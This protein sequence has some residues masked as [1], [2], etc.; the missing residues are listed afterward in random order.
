MLALAI[1]C[2]TARASIALKK[3]D[4]IIFEQFSNNPKTH[5]EFLN[6]SIQVSLQDSGFDLSE[7]D[8]FAC[9][10]GPGSFTGIRVASAIVKT[11]A[12]L[13]RKPIFV[14]DSLALLSQGAYQKD[15][16]LGQILCLINAHK[17][18]AY[19]ALYQKNNS[20]LLEPCS[21]KV[22]EIGKISGLN[23]ALGLG[24]GFAAYANSLNFPDYKLCFRDSNYSDFPEATVLAGLALSALENGKT[25]DWNL[26]KPL[27]IRDSEAEE[28]LR[29]K[30]K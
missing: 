5:S 18:M 24:D 29:L 11:F 2:S 26:Y 21:L 14:I 20:A 13:F 10:S 30:T 15:P 27:Y 8:V 28:V 6:S 25:I 7:I 12:M 16:S 23:Q 4:Q 19:T 1:E 3:N 22:E 9:S 17:N